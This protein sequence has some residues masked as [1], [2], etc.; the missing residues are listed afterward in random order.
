MYCTSINL[1]DVGYH[2]VKYHLEKC[3]TVNINNT[4]QQSTL[5]TLLENNTVF[6]N[7]NWHGIVLNTVH[8]NASN[9]SK[10]RQN[11]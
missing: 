3:T 8:L 9:Y 5:H 1:K 2:G 7:M 10:I 11:E 4:V 6:I